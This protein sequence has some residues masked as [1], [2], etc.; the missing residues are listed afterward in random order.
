MAA[1]RDGKDIALAN[2]ETLVVAGDLIRH[3]LTHVFQFTLTGCPSNDA[4]PEWLGVWNSDA[5][6]QDAKLDGGL[7]LIETLGFRGEALPSIGSV[8]RLLLT[9]RAMGADTAWQ[10]EAD[11]GRLSDP[12]PRP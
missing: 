9:S 12:R 3:E 1:I 6:V 11:N 7:E 10:V 8:A 2:K 4:C 5:E